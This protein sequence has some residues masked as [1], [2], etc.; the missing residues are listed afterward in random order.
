MD[1]GLK[2]LAKAAGTVAL[3]V[4]W[5]PASAGCADPAEAG[6]HP[7]PGTRCA[8]GAHPAI[9]SL[10][11]WRVHPDPSLFYRLTPAELTAWFGELRQQHQAVCLSERMAV[12]AG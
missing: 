4:M 11:V 5:T 3:L 9:R 2:A 7:D 1:D 10:R 6:V 8:C 12:P